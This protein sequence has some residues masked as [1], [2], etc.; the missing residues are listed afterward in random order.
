MI[1]TKLR[2]IFGMLLGLALLLTLLPS[3]ASAA[4][5]IT[6]GKTA[7]ALNAQNE[8]EVTLSFPGK[9][10][11]FG[12]D[13]VF[14]LDKSG[15]SDEQGVNKQALDFLADIKQQADE[16]NLNVKIGV[17]S[18]NYIGNVRSELKDIRT[19]YNDIITAMK[20]T[21]SMGT[22]MHAGLLAAQEMLD[23]DTTVKSNRKHFVLISDGA[24]YLYCNDGDYTKAYTRS[25]GNPKAQTN[26]ATG[27][28][29]PYG[30]DR[31]GGI[32]EY[33]SREYNTPNNTK[34]FSDGTNF[35]FS[36]ASSATGTIAKLDEY[37]QYYKQQDADADKNWPQYEYEYN[38]SSAYL[39]I[40]RI[41]TP[42][43]FNAPANIDVAWWRTDDTFQEMVNSGY[44]SYVFFKNAA[45]FDGS[46]FL[47][48]LVR[49]S[50]G[51]QLST[52][53]ATLTKKVNN[54]IDKG[55]VVQD[56]I[57][58]DFDFINDP[59]RIAVKVGDETLQPVAIAEN[60]YGFGENSDGTYRYEL[61][62]NA[63][64]NTGAESLDLKVN[65]TVFPE[66]PVQLIYSEKLVNIPTAS[67]S[68]EF[69]VNE[70]AVLMPMDSE[71]ETLDP[72]TFP[73][74]K[75]TLRVVNNA[76]VSITKTFNGL[77][78]DENL[79][80]S[81]R[82]II[83]Q[84]NDPMRELTLADFT[85]DNG[86]YTYTMEGEEGSTYSVTESGAEVN[87]YRLKTTLPEAAQLGDNG[88][89]L[90]IINTYKKTGGGGGGGGSTYLSKTVT[91][92][93]EDDNNAAGKRPESVTIQLYRDNEA[94]GDPVTITE[95]DNWKHTWS[96][97][98][99]SGKYTVG[100]TDIGAG[101]TSSVDQS[102]LTITNTYKKPDLNKTDHDAYI[103]G[104]PDGTVQPQGNI[105]R[106][107][108]AVIYFRLLTADSRKAYWDT[109]CSF[110]D[111]NQGDWYNN[112]I[113][114]LQNAGIL[115]GDGSAF[116]PNDP[117]TRAELAVIATRFDEFSGK[118][119]GSAAFN[120]T[121][122]HWAEAA[123]A[124]AAE[125]GWVKGYPDGS[126][127]PDAHI[128]RAETMTL[129]NRVLERAVEAEGMHPDMIVWPDNPADAWYYAEVQEA[130]NSHIY[131]RTEKKVDG[132]SFNYEKWTAIKA[133]PS[134]D[135]E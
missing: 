78:P 14:V 35:I 56:Q 97:L 40:G 46:L 54:L 17:V 126:F 22:N 66:K 68:Y 2:N 9:E 33:Q 37:L 104:Y 58:N 24:T 119:G 94:Y 123:I 115:A 103:V 15:A 112:A 100:E 55:S 98:P 71:G 82:V 31:K 113:A 50:S 130:T 48:Y 92:V 73:V 3:A 117:I 107:E 70:S 102:S 69:N 62:Y 91:K 89:T 20:Q 81:I 13:I 99:K 12:T 110:S 116:R 106:A 132:Y 26:P 125:I 77:E 127:K 19:N 28:P 21:T 60:T 111:V 114:T 96:R 45:D 49:N 30:S 65:E 74:P 59:S 42:I 36:Q 23:N 80:G 108:A 87:G 120:D 16:K 1:K 10:D 90:P 61:V 128:T 25:F 18:F 93:W 11:Q 27:A 67:G 4:D 72:I 34:Q 43:D 83:A 124:H 85:E 101:Y 134:W 32:W 38:F 75:V 105:T 118:T 84:N 76:P 64:S 44:Q 29:Y 135:V 7:T 47:K 95:E 88:L 52:D 133:V 41:V 57:G 121:K 131:I 86:V 122:G 109:E 51:G 129:I 39:G 53:F 63:D 5:I 79:L 6:P 8:T